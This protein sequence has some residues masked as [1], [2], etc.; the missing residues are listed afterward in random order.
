M[1]PILGNE[2]KNESLTRTE[3]MKNRFKPSIQT[4]IIST[5]SHFFSRSDPN[6]WYT[7]LVVYIFCLSLMVGYMYCVTLL[8]AL[9]A[10][11]VACV[12]HSRSFTQERCPSRE[13]SMHEQNSVEVSEQEKA[14]FSCSRRQ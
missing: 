12:K 6:K 7:V 3:C 8:R 10:G 9:L 2:G 5:F 11:T 4:V 14:I 13:F 1:K